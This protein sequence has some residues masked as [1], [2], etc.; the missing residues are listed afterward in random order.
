MFPLDP[1]PIEDYFS[2]QGRFKPLMADAE[3]LD[4]VR[5]GVTER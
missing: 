5:E 4:L 3:M 1:L 2:L